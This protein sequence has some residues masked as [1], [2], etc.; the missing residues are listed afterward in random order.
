MTPHHYS[1]ENFLGALESQ[2]SGL[3]L[4]RAEALRF[5]DLQTI[6]THVTDLRVQHRRVAIMLS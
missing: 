1:C 2:R 3:S 5:N 4:I 6:E